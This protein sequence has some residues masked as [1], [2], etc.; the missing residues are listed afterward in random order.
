VTSLDEAYSKNWATN[1]AER[2]HPGDTVTAYVNPGA[3]GDS[4]LVQEVSC[5][6]YLVHGGRRDLPADT[7]VR[8]P[9]TARANL[10]R[11]SA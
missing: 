7:E 4:F 1:W 11:P 10:S 5:L 9:R 3:P 2:F 6:S 8:E